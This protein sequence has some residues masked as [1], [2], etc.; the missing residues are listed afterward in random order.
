[1]AEIA[2]RELHDACGPLRKERRLRELGENA[3]TNRALP[4]ESRRQHQ[5]WC[6]RC[7]RRRFVCTIPRS[8]GEIATGG[9]RRGRGKAAIYIVAALCSGGMRDG[10]GTMP[11]GGADL[12]KRS[13]VQPAV[14]DTAV[15]GPAISSKFAGADVVVTAFVMENEQPDRFWHMG[16][17]RRIDD[18]QLAAG[19]GDPKIVQ[20]RI[21][22][23]AHV[24]ASQTPTANTQ[25][26]IALQRNGRR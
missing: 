6:S 23:V 14:L 9:R 16:N 18:E 11:E 20:A 2:R 12:A 22:D 1:V 15:D 26:A 25:T 17:E 10:R 5:A 19:H 21:K 8:A 3:L 24:P 13:L 7:D 4:N